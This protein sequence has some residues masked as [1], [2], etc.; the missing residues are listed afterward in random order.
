MFFIMNFMKEVVVSPADLSKDLKKIVRVKLLEQITG[1][2]NSKY[3]YFI[4]VIKIGDVSNGLIMEG[5]GDII[6]KMEYRV[7]LM[8]PFKGEICDGIIDTVFDVGGIHV[9]VG[10]MVVH[11]AKDDMQPNYVLD[12]KNLCYVNEKDNI[13]LRKGTKV[14]FKFKDIRF[15]KNEFKPTGTMRA[16]YLGYI[17]DN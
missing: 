8:R 4:K 11:I 17:Q 7:V 3:G 15:D 16:D 1:T 6:F 14:R 10:P 9:K 5:T 12:K 13:E 2:C